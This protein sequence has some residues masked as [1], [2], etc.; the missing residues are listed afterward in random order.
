MT[1]TPLVII[2][3]S[4][5]PTPRFLPLFFDSG[6]FIMFNL[7]GKLRT[8]EALKMRCETGTSLGPPLFVNQTDVSQS[9]RNA[10]TADRSIRQLPDDAPMLPRGRLPINQL[11]PCLRLGWQRDRNARA[12]WRFQR[13]VSAITLDGSPIDHGCAAEPAGA[14]MRSRFA[15][16]NQDLN[17]R[18]AHRHWK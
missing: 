7:M 14:R 13:M 15:R 4:C 2:S 9:R 8:Q 17:R 18:L 6:E 11:L 16:I 12:H 3:R 1:S 10:L 5:I